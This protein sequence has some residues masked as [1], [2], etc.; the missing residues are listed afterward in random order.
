[1]EQVSTP[2][3]LFSLSVD[4]VA[5]THLAETAKW[6]RFL[7]IIGF[8]FLGLGLVVGI[9]SILTMSYATGN[10]SG[11]TTGFAAIASMGIAGFI[12]VYVIVGL[13]IFFPLLF[14]LRFA[15]KMK[16]ALASD[17]QQRLNLSFQNLKAYFRFWGIIAIIGLAF[18]A[19]VFLFA[20][21]GTVLS[22]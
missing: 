21:F 11:D 9:L 22:G 13:I 15:N 16:A 1:M 17:D 20:I 18:Y 6:A 8:I 5:K 7:A 4:P 3:S 2:S 12:L 10:M 14:L 19:I